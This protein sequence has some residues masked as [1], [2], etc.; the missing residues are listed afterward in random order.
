L[1]EVYRVIK[2]YDL[3]TNKPVFEKKM[4][5][6]AA[7]PTV[8]TAIARKLMY[9]A[10]KREKFHAIIKENK[11]KLWKR[12]STLKPVIGFPVHFQSV[13]LGAGWFQTAIVTDVAYYAG[14][15]EFQLPRIVIKTLTSV[16][17]VEVDD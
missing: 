7:I 9:D 8:P 12:Q 10:H 13:K 15:P 16:Y 17:L 4:Y 14:V 5:G 3:E 6:Q 1:G 11:I 2:I